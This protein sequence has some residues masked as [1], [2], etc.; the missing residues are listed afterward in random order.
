M[1]AVFENARSSDAQK[2]IPLLAEK[3]F[4]RVFARHGD[5]EIRAAEF[6]ADVLA[7][8]ERL[9]DARYALN[10]C[11]QRY[12]FLVAFCAAI[13]AGQTNLLPATRAPLYP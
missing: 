9:P 13:V 2:K 12:H 3:D 8:A 4:N 1:S 5:R 10:L 7:L 6:L 11:T